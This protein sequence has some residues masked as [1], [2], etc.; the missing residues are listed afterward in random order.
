MLKNKVIRRCDL[1]VEYNNIDKNL[2]NYCTNNVENI[3]GYTTGIYI[4]RAYSQ[5]GLPF[6]IGD[7]LLEINGYKI[8]NYGEIKVEWSNEK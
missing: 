5:S 2:W 4:K 7:I 8:D 6:S 1:L 3:D